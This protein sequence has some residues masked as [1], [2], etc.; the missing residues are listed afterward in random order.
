MKSV[1]ILQLAT[2]ESVVGFICKR[3]W[4]AIEMFHPLSMR[5]GHDDEGNM[6]LVMIPYAPFSSAKPVKFF[7][8]QITSAS[9]PRKSI[10][11]L[12]ISKGGQINSC[13]VDQLIHPSNMQNTP[14]EK[15]TVH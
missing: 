8:W 4:F 13:A 3:G 5:L 10:R 6:M 15:H 2:G 9:D 14:T 1:K 11:D 7:R 12:Y